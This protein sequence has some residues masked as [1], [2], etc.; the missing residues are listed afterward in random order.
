MQVAV[1]NDAWLRSRDMDVEVRGSLNVA[2]D[3]LAEDLR[4]TGSLNV[5]RGTY[6]L[7]Y[8]PLQSRRF[9]VR[10][11]AIEFPGTPGIDPSLSITAAY[12][13]RA[14]NEPLDILAT[15]TGTLQNPRVRLASD[16][17]PPYSESDLASYLFFGVPTWQV[18]SSGGP[19]SAD[20]RAVAGLGLG[21]LRPSVLGYA[22]SGLQTLV[23]SAGLLDYVGLTAAEVSPGSSALLSGTQLELGRY[24]LDSRIF[25]GYAQRLGSPGL[26]PAVRLEWKFLPEYSLEVFSEDRFART[27]GFGARSEAGMRKVYGFS[28]FREWGF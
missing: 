25:V 7:Y 20:V 9:Q 1:A 21:A 5:E 19:G 18:A 15:V 6:T 10:S 2:F 26:D 12:K 3:R 23:Q 27:P 24:W 16:A 13:A 17:Q 14:N 11:G 28:L 8:P 4:L 22:S